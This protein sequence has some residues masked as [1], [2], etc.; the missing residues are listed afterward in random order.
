MARN[1]LEKRLEDI[2]NQKSMYKLRIRRLEKE[3]IKILEEL[4]VFKKRGGNA[5]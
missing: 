2:R 1:H 3:E 4:G 5:L